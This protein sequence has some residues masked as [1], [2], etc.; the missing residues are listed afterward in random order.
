MTEGSGVIDWLYSISPCALYDKATARNEAYAEALESVRARQRSLANAEGDEEVARKAR[1]VEEAVENARQVGLKEDLVHDAE[2]DAEKERRPEAEKELQTSSDCHWF[3]HVKDPDRLEEAIKTARAVQ[4]DEA[5]I[6]PAQELLR[7]ARAAHA[8]EE[9]D[10]ARPKW[11]NR[12]PDADTLEAALS[13]CRELAP[14]EKALCREAEAELKVLRGIESARASEAAAEAAGEESQG[15]SK[16]RK[17][18][19]SSVSSAKRKA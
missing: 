12:T 3:G 14:E 17:S 18:S 7:K 16:Q 13:S 15:A 19:T 4:V 11:W 10:A 2:V 6:A 5:K 9:L 8:K 1:E